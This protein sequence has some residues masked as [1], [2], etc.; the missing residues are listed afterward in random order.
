MAKGCGWAI[1]GGLI[2]FL[3]PGTGWAGAIYFPYLGARASG[4]GGSFVARA[5]DVSTV[6]HNP[7]GML[8]LEANEVGA[9]F[10]LN[11]ADFQ[12]TRVD[13]PVTFDPVSLESSLNPQPYLGFVTS[14]PDEG[15][16]IGIGIS[17]AFGG[18]PDYPDDGPQRY[19]L[20]YFRLMIVHN[21]V[22]SAYRITDGLTLGGG[23]SLIY[24]KLQQRKSI[25]ARDLL[26]VPELITP[27]VD[28]PSNEIITTLD[29]SDWAFGVDLG[30]LYEP[31][32]WLRIGAHYN[33]SAK[34]KFSGTIVG[35]VSEIELFRLLLGDEFDAQME[36]EFDLPK[37]ARVGFAIVPE[38]PL[39]FSADLFWQ[40]WSVVK[41]NR[42]Q[43][44]GLPGLDEI[45]VLR[46][47]QDSWVLSTGLEYQLS[48]GHALRA[49]FFFDQGAIPTSTVSVDD[50]DSDKI[51]ITGGVTF[52]ASKSLLV[53]LSA[54]YRKFADIE[55]TD[56]AYNTLDPN[57]VGGNTNGTYRSSI[58]SFALG[59]RYRFKS[60]AGF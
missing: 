39:S 10:H 25:D 24:G 4:M 23:V 8:L 26:G 38:G 60:G 53:D 5:D 37:I 51:G 21:T 57:I 42:V 33:H 31:L 52:R 1:L 47:W 49:G 2:F 18:L 41:E 56:S 17:A 40:N 7:A 27:G 13:G 14:R 20:D 12:Y 16:A 58:M 3:F 50:P 30:L 35:D 48:G 45:V 54:D 29:G 44:K 55:V 15:Y 28:D 43:I 34:L 36:T 19:L 11:F 59:V 32:P 9:S 46:D 22:A 6:F